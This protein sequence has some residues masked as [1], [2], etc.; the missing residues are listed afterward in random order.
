MTVLEASPDNP[1]PF[2]PHTLTAVDDMFLVDGRRT[3][4]AGRALGSFLGILARILARNVARK[5]RRS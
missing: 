3:V 2:G 1:F 5:V 4:F